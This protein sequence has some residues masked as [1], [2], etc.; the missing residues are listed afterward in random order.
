MKRI[1]III[2]I[3]LSVFSLFAQSK[4]SLF[5][6]SLILPGWGQVSSGKNYGYSM[7]AAEVAILSSMYYFNNEYDLKKQEA[8]EYAVKYADVLPGSYS[9]NYFAHLSRYNSSG[10]EAG[11]YNAMIREQAMITYP[12][13]PDMQQQYINANIYGDD[14]SWSWQSDSNR[15][16]FGNI[17]GDMNKNKDYTRI[18]IGVTILNHFV[19]AI[20]ILRLD[21][22]RKRSKLHFGI[23]DDSPMLFV[24]YSF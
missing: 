11:G 16:I 3:V 14:M 18:V 4:G 5:L 24:D 6:K 17:R 8:Y 2:V 20:D 10:F 12:N 19:S 22:E 9:D 7:M 21:A 1:I 23:K 15:R 13:Q